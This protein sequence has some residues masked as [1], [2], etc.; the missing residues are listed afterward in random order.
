MA[1]LPKK[2]TSETRIS[3]ISAAAMNA[4]VQATKDNTAAIKNLQSR[5]RGPR[6]T[7]APVREK[8]CVVTAIGE[9][10]L[11]VTRVTYADVPPQECSGSGAERECHY[12]LTGDIFDA[13]PDFGWR[14]EDYRDDVFDPETGTLDESTAFLRAYMEE[15]TWR[16]QKPKA[17]GGA[18][19]FAIPIDTPGFTDASTTLMVQPLR[20]DDGVEF[21]DEGDPIEVF[22]WP[23]TRGRH[24]R[25]MIEMQQ[26]P[27]IRIEKH[28]G[29]WYARQMWP[30][31]TRTPDP[32]LEAGDCPLGE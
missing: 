11:Q 12:E 30:W 26:S 1:Q 14:A 13:F 10:V 25:K 5:R 32:A 6:A 21:V 19:A 9:G 4:L 2:I 15:S 8:T 3:D 31:T 27:V 17:A 24:Y 20:S 16:L 7:P 23:R 22:V 28:G 29:D 18:F